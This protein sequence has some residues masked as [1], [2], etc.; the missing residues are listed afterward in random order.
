MNFL[1]TGWA[2]LQEHVDQREM[3]CAETDHIRQLTKT[4]GKVA[5]A[6][7]GGSLLQ[8]MSTHKV[9]FENATIKRRRA[10]GN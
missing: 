1:V 9:E 3:I 5:T 2:S 8:T 4:P 7:R 10:G 6:P